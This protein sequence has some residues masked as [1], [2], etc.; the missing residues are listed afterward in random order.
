MRLSRPIKAVAGI[1]LMSHLAACGTIL[2]PERKGQIDGRIDP[3]VAVL[4]GLG[5][6]FYLI[7]GVI[8]FAVDFNNGTIYLPDTANVEGDDDGVRVVKSDEPLSMDNL[9]EKVE[10]A[11]GEK[12][13][14]SK[15][16]VSRTAK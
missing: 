10:Q 2:Y 3:S 15:A 12:V 6:L 16:Q 7:P 1:L 13:D 11:T 9:A 5:L 8:A 14:L 4:D